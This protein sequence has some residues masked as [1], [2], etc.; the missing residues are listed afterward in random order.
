MNIVCFPVIDW[1]FLFQ[2]AKHTTIWLA[3]KGHSIIYVNPPSNLPRDVHIHKPTIQ[4]ITDARAIKFVTITPGNG[5]DLSEFST[6]SPENF[7]YHG[8]FFARLIPEKGIFDLIEIWKLVVKKMPNAK[9]AVCG[10][11]E[12]TE[13][14]KKFLKEVSKYNLSNNIEFLGQQDKAKLLN[15]VAN[16]YLTVYPSYVD[17]FSLVTLES[18]ACGTPVIAY[19]IPAIRHNFRKCKSV[20]R[21][22][23]GNKTSMADTILH[24]LTKMERKTLTIE[25]KKFATSYDWDKVVKAEKEAYAQVINLNRQA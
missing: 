3:R 17:S 6:E 7:D 23:V 18:L 25:A 19:D 12:E 15:I 24:V 1:D 8:V 11:A 20:F 4:Y 22:P 10:I 2:R 14:V 16:S 21:C 5:I 9:L 13:I